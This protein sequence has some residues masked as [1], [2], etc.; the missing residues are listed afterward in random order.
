MI[1]DWLDRPVLFPETT[2]AM[3]TS[4]RAAYFS[5]RASVTKG[6]LALILCELILFCS[7]IIVVHGFG[8]NVVEDV[9]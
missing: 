4:D 9:S 3:L 5:W 8:G 7:V 2:S 1:R 6:Y